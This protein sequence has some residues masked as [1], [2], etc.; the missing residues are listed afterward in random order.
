MKF[1]DVLGPSL[2]SK[3][4][5]VTLEGQLRW[6]EN[7]GPPGHEDRK[8]PQEVALLPRPLPSGCRG[9]SGPQQLVGCELF[10][11]EIIYNHSLYS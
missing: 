11:R 6:E 8:G 2:F 10:K 7:P 3:T 4:P 5:K 9:F 1:G